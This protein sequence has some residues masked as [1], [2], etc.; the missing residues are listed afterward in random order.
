M[1]PNNDSSFDEAS[2]DGLRGEFRAIPAV[3]FL[4]DVFQVR[5]DAFA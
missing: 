3:E 4:E 5:A 1:G 2:D